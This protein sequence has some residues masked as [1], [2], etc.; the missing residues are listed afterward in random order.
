MPF[1][2][3]NPTSPCHDISRRETGSPAPSTCHAGPVLLGAAR[4]PALSSH[5]P[6]PETER[7]PVADEGKRERRKA[8]G[9]VRR[10]A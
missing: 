5:R 8:E 4:S 2:D 3:K 6:S 10:K 7:P 1:S 9:H